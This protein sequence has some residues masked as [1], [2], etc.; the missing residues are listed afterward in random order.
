[1]LK[2]ELLRALQAEI[3]LHDFDT[4]PDKFPDGRF[5]VVPG[6]PHC[7]KRFETTAQFVEHLTRDVLPPL[8]DRLA[9]KAQP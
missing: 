8:L 6:C 7:K 2:S 9:A 5:I 3:S 4:F 1:M